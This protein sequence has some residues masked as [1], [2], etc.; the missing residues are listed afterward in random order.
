[1]SC[2][3]NLKDKLSLWG[4]GVPQIEPGYWHVTKASIVTSTEALSGLR[5]LRLASTSDQ[6]AGRCVLVI[7]LDVSCY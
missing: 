1:M 7:E 2:L 4:K 5:Q 6:L 3:R